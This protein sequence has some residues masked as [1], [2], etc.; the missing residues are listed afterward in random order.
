METT[1]IKDLLEPP[2]SANNLWY[3]QRGR[4][5]E[6][7][8]NDMLSKEEMAPRT[9]MR[10][11]GE[12]I[13]GSF[14]IDHSFYLLEA[15][16]H[17]KTIPASALY[18]FKGKVDG[19]LIGTIGV[20]FSM[21]DYSTDAVDALLSGKEL[22]LILFG[23]QDLLLIESGEITMRDAIYVKLRYAADYG[24]P[25]YPLEVYFSNEKQ[26]NHNIQ[27]QNK[28]WSILVESEADA[29][30]IDTL[31]KRFH[32]NTNFDVFPAGGQLAVAQLAEHLVKT[33]AA[34]IGVF[35]TPISDP[36]VQQKVINKLEDLGLDLVVLNC[37]LESWLGKYVSVEVYNAM[38]MLSDYNGKMARRYARSADLDKLISDNPSFSELLTK[39]GAQSKA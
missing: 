22:N 23:R 24:Q 30:I 8:L 5:F 35:I 32:T 3:Q 6:R 37:D 27:T 28:P 18:S 34:N 2:E 16:W 1:R 26:T 31:F 19:K 15:K 29:R 21:S 39:I 4:H 20:F 12:E 9:S 13:D 25:F 17:A 33:Y 10:P 38:M 7:I 11:S 36:D 14:S